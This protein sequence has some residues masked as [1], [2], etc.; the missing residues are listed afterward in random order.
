MQKVRVPGIHINHI[1]SFSAHEFS[2]TFKH[3]NTKYITQTQIIKS[4]CLFTLSVITCQLTVNN[5]LI[6]CRPIYICILYRLNL[7]IR[8]VLYF[9]ASCPT[10]T[11]MFPAAHITGGS[12]SDERMICNIRPDNIKIPVS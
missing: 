2:I 9:S 10:D 12:F 8:H 4:V 5:R 1:K 3:S 11:V 7:G 6:S